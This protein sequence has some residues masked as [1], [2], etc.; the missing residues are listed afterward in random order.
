MNSIKNKS[1]ML[2]VKELSQMLFLLLSV[3]TAKRVAFAVLVLTSL[4]VFSNAQSILTLEEAKAV[5]LSNNYGIKVAQNNV[6]IAKNNTDKRANGY[7]PTVNAT[8]GLNGS[9]G[10]SE[11]TF[12][13]GMENKVSNAFQWS[14]NAAVNANYTVFDK[15]RDLTLEQLKEN[16]TLVNLQLRQT[17][18]NNLLQVYNGFFQVAQ[19]EENI[20]AL[21]QAMSISRERLQRAN[22]GLEYGQG[23]G[24]TVLNAEVDIQRDS[25]NILNAQQQLANARRNLNVL[26]GRNTN[27]IFVTDADLIYAD[28]LQLTELT[29]AAKNENIAL[30]IN[31]RNL[32]VN[33]MT[34]GIIDAERKPTITT[35]ASYT[36]S[37]SDNAAEAF[38]TSSNSRGLGAN[39][40][41]NWNIFDGGSRKI[42]EENT[43]V[44]LSNQK[45]QIIQLEQQTEA[46]IINAWES[47]Q[48]ALYILE[49]QESAV[50][51]NEENFAR[52][53]EQ[54]RI[55]RI[56]SLE[57]RQAQ[58]NL[59]NAQVS[60]NQAKFD[61]KVREIQMLQ[62][63]GQL[64]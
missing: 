31:R 41:L 47:Y 19:L 62:L 18:E 49:V 39:V 37:Y 26:M 5:T 8:G 21:E 54:L 11:Q 34:L 24:L 3:N 60:L 12:S 52:T 35:G 61:A 10:G 32:A 51:T 14:A 48:N 25:V 64:Q 16:V 28:N 23:S 29:N 58:L 40:S 43:R 2:T 30:Q 7:L 59:L 36:Y 55:G 53:E 17:I 9:L 22:Y 15:R 4:P 33:E 1:E 44:N 38:I 46:Q 13:S 50:T 6:Q 57:F 45:L 63:A 27:E 20:S 42:R 56:S